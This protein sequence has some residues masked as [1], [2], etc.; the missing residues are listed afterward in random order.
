M[1]ATTGDRESRG[2]SSLTIIRQQS[3]SSGERNCLRSRVVAFS[4]YLLRA[5]P[6]PVPVSH[7]SPS[8]VDD[9]LVFVTGG[10][11][12]VVPIIELC[13]WVLCKS[14]HGILPLPGLVDGEGGLEA[15]LV[16]WPS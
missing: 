2:D 4:A 3:L 5:V 8:A 14:C 11:E 15:V 9:L 12:E 10:L 13:H 1:V 7:S 6:C 16:T